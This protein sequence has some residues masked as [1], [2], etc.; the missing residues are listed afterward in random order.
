MSAEPEPRREPTLLGELV[1][2]ALVLAVGTGHVVVRW[3]RRLT[4]L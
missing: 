2:V 4:G 1:I 3:F